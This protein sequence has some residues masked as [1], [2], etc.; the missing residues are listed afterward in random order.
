V[1]GVRSKVFPNAPP[2][3]LFSGDQGVPEYGPESDLNNI[4]PRIGFAYDVFGNGRTSVRGGSGIFY[5]SRVPA[6]SNNRELGAAPY[7][8]SVS[9]TTPKG[10]FSNPYL[11]IVNPFPAQFPPSSNATFTSPVQVYSWD[12]ANKFVTPA[13]YSWNLAVEQDLT[14]DW[15]ARLAYVGSRANHLTVTVDDNPAVYIPGSSAS[16]DQRRLYPGFSNIYQASNAGSAWYHSMQATLQKRFSHGLTINVNY[17]FSKSTDTLPPG[18]DAATFGTAGFYTLPVYAQ[19]FQ[20]D[21]RG[22][23][24]FDRRHVF[25]SSY[26]WQTP[27]LAGMSRVVRAVAGSWELSGVLSAQSGGPLTIL[28]GKD[29]S[30]TGA[31]RDRGQ[32]L[33]SQVYANVLCSA[34]PCVSFLNATAFG[35]PSTGTFG[36]AGKGEFTGPGN[37]NWDL[38]LF[39]FFPVNDRFKIQFR[40]EFFNVLN[41]ANFLNPVTTVSGAGF[42]NIL[43][44]TDPRILQFALKVFF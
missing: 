26:V 7:A 42:G 36:N 12:P 38:G 11:G 40:S 9:L 17:T 27:R 1:Q 30:L 43:S 16:T 18:T 37:F 34:A 29:Q 15:L 23:S 8:S 32:V 35:L 20:Q 28:A 4:A 25:V 39:K 6:F 10:P 31:G 21:D 22:R 2:G 24:D 14:R 44:A 19:N 3:L 13:N 33:T 41:R 5:D